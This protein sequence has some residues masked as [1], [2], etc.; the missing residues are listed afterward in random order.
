MSKPPILFNILI[1][2]VPIRP[3]KIVIPFNT[4]QQHLLETFFQPEIGE[5]DIDETPTQIKVQ[6]L[7]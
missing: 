7:C 2:L 3:I 5:M 4:F 1:K 6:K